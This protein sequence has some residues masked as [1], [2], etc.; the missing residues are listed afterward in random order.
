MGWIVKLVEAAKLARVVA[1]VVRDA[2]AGAVDLAGAR[3]RL[4]RA[5]ERGDLD[6]AVAV[7]RKTASKIREAAK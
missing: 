4:A 3:E 1:P 2:V 5:A 6:D 7:A